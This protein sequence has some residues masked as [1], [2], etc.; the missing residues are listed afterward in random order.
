MNRIFL[1]ILIAFNLSNT[2]ES[3]FHYI[4]QID[5]IQKLEFLYKESLNMSDTLK[6][7]DIL[8]D[9]VDE[10]ESSDFY[11]DQFISDYY[12]E[13]GN[14][15]LLINNFEKSEFFFLQ[16]IE[17]YNKS[18]LKNQ[19]LM[20]GPLNDLQSIYKLKN[21][22]INLNATLKRI[23]KIKDLKN[24]SLLDSIKYS[25]LSIQ[26]FDESI[27]NEI[28]ETI[29]NYIELSNQAFNQRLYSKSIEN[30]ML[31]LNYESPEIDYIYYYN[32]PILD[33]INIEYIYP[34]IEN[35][36]K[37][38]NQNYSYNFL[39]SIINIKLQDYEKALSLAKDYYIAQKSDIKSYEL[40]ADIYFKKEIWDQSLFYY[41][42]SLL[43]NKNNLELRFKIS[44][45]MNYMEKYDEAISSLDYII[46]NDPYFYKAYLELGKIYILKDDLKKSQKILTDFLLF[47]PNSSEGYYYLGVSYFK[48]K[49]YS[50]AM[51][52]F[53]RAINLDNSYADAHYYLGIIKE[54][55]LKY[56][57]AEYH[58]KKARVLE[59]SFYDINFY[60]GNLLYNLEKYK[61]A[62]KPL[63]QY[64]DYFEYENYITLS[65]NYKNSLIMLGEIF[66]NKK[67]YSEAI[68]VYE[69]LIDKYPEDLFFNSQLA[70][71]L[72]LLKNYDRAIE[73]Y[74]YILNLYSEDT[75]SMLKLGDIYFEKA[76]YY[77]ASNY[78]SQAIN[79]SPKNKDALYKTALCYAYT[80]KFFQALIAFKRANIISPDDLLIMYQIGVTYMELEIYNQAIPYF[81]KNKNDPEAQFMIGICYYKSNNYNKAL[82]YFLLYLNDEK[83]NSEL[84]YYI[85][86]CYYFLEDYNKSAKN[87]KTS[88]KIDSSNIDTLS[89]LGASYIKLGKKREAQKIANKLYYLDKNEYNSLNRLINSN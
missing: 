70:K 44:S 71:A 34:T 25:Q 55:I 20:E 28:A 7:I 10:A 50:F 4:D 64:I 74:E 5:R 53:N 6:S 54:S 75:D 1:I 26:T 35:L 41:F 78:Y 8:L 59:T 58:Y 62:I 19:L 43:N 14:L 24:N 16:S 37:S 48:Q 27:E 61:N 2:E 17:S 22:S 3:T 81:E 18:M 49:K 40:L 77:L 12:Y 39:N 88:L 57:D 79:C 86:L 65:D 72:F 29:H 76:D 51:D 73:I 84:Y 67:R 83:D 56:S 45:C 85:G 15:Y 11:S 63:E 46:K 33:S 60:Y 87:L 80:E 21:D 69:K 13:I 82:D 47:K 31:S 68:V 36:S 52:A 23:K 89:K 42:R 32:L 30:L 9:I 66:F 38:D